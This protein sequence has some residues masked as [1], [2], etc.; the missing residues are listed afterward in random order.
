MQLQRWVC[1][2]HKPPVAQVDEPG[3][4]VHIL[5]P[6]GEQAQEVLVWAHHPA[7]Q[8]QLNHC[9][10]RQKGVSLSIKASTVIVTLGKAPRAVAKPAG[11]KA[12]LLHW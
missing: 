12:A 5:G 10:Q 2:G 4:R 6:P 8:P 11:H 1:E 7:P 3:G 9:F